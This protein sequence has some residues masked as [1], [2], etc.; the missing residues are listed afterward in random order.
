MSSMETDIAF[1]LLLIR[2]HFP[3][4][5]AQTLHVS[6]DHTII[7]KKSP[8][9]YALPDSVQIIPVPFSITVRLFPHSMDYSEQSSGLD[10]VVH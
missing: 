8:F 7:Q 6:V 9:V 5:C 1:T 2:L 10:P 4:E 3:D